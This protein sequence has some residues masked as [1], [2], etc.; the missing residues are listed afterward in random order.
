VPDA[1]ELEAIARRAGAA[2][3]PV[4]RGPEGLE[5]ADPSGNRVL[6]RASQG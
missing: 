1:D 2:G 6:V 3:V 4:G 5:L